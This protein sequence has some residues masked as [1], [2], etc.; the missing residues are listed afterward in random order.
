MVRPET[1]PLLIQTQQKNEDDE[2]V[3]ELQDEL[4]Q[5]NE[6]LQSFQNWVLQK[7][8]EEMKVQVDKDPPDRLI[9]QKEELERPGVVPPIEEKQMQ[10]EYRSKSG[11]LFDRGNRKGFIRDTL[12]PRVTSLRP[13][14]IL[15]TNFTYE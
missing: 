8:P 11:K 4:K 12:L 15:N 13:L 3:K 10:S 14:E 2:T 1:V 5:Q 6:K 7:E 9:E